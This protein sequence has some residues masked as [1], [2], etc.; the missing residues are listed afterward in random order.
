M[1]L[2]AEVRVGLR[3]TIGGAIVE[4]WG[5][6]AEL[7]KAGT[8]ENEVVAF[9]SVNDWHGENGGQSQEGSDD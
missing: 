2:S 9:L 1:G 4:V 6:T 5:R 7:C 8:D 3:L